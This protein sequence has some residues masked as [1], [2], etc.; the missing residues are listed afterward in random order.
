MPVDIRM[1]RSAGVRTCGVTYGNGSRE[2]L[3][4]AGADFLVDTLP[5]LLRLI[6]FHLD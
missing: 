6:P 4:A 5:E 3:L 2:A 1:G